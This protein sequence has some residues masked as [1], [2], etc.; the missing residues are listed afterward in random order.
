MTEEE[1]HA[2]AHLNAE[3]D[4][5]EALYA[6]FYDDLCANTAEAMREAE[7]KVEESEKEA[8]EA[9]LR[10]GIAKVDVMKLE[11]ALRE[12]HFRNPK[13]GRLGRKGERF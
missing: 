1:L 9:R 5:R 8:R 13:T 11:A 12:A 6:T 10:A 3:H 4:V 7:R 2:E